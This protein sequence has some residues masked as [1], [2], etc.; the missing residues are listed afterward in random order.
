MRDWQEDPEFVLIVDDLPTS[1]LLL[2]HVSALGAQRCVDLVLESGVSLLGTDGNGLQ[3]LQSAAEFRRYELLS[4]LLSKGVYRLCMPLDCERLIQAVRDGLMPANDPC[5][6]LWSQTSLRYTQFSTACVCEADRTAATAVIV[7]LVQ[8][9]RADIDYSRVER[10]I[11]MY[12]AAYLGMLP[13]VRG[14]VDAGVD[15]NSRG[16]C[17]GSALNAAIRGKHL[18]IV[19][20]LLEQQADV[21][22]SLN[23]S[24]TTPLHLAC[25]AQNESLLRMLL[26]NGALVDTTIF[27]GG[28]ALHTA[29]K[30]KNIAIAKILLEYN[31]DVNISD[32]TRGTP[33]HVACETGDEKMFE[34]LLEHGADVNVNAPGKG[35]AL[36]MACHSGNKTITKRLLEHGAKVDVFSESHGTPLHVA[37][38]HGDVTTTKILL[39][40]G[41]DVNAKDSE[42]QMP[43]TRLLSHNNLHS[44]WRSM[45]ALINSYARV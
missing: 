34:L 15:V 20:F 2:T 3:A 39:E 30:T 13:S 18:G 9:A 6:R 43:L 45:D 41:A 29:C 35:A 40:H 42:D 31:A 23:Q 4:E 44:I 11:F 38:H 27:T 5:C 14:W 10:G 28:A 19:Q 21:N 7:Q 36:H 16:G 33:L 26:Q 37:C 17:F 22:L 32:L 24:H 1:Q 12:S 8:I 25:K